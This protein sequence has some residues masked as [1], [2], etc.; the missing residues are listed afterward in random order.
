VLIEVY[1]AGLNPFDEI[2]RNSYSAYLFPAVFPLYLGND[3]SGV[4]VDVG[5]DCEL[6]KKGDEV[7]GMPPMNRFGSLL[8]ILSFKRNI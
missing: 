1:A 3:F 5:E 8:N 7:Y 4:V 2:L 6:F